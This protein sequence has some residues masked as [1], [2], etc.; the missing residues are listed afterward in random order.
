MLQTILLQYQRRNRM[1]R[2]FMFAI[3]HKNYTYMINNCWL[4][5]A[6]GKLISATRK[7][8]RDAAEK[9]EILPKLNEFIFDYKK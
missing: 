1:N 3:Y 7:K 9:K 6:R 4:M 2:Y 5:F 8:S